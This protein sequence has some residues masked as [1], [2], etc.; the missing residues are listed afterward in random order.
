VTGK[1]YYYDIFGL[2]PFGEPTIEG[3]GGATTHL[4]PAG[5]SQVRRA[6]MAICWASG[7]PVDGMSP[8]RAGFPP[9]RV[10]PARKLY[11]IQ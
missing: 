5:A 7:T 2:T 10:G 11:G 1:V 3:Q 6:V 9:S 4:V 8:L